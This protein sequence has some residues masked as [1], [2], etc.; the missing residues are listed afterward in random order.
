VQKVLISVLTASCSPIFLQVKDHPVR[1][2]C[3]AGWATGWSLCRREN[4]LASVGN[5]VTIPRSCTPWSSR[6]T[7]WATLAPVSYLKYSYLIF[8]LLHRRLNWEY[9]GWSGTMKASYTVLVWKP[10]RKRPEI[11]RWSWAYNQLYLQAKGCDSV[12][13]VNLSSDRVKGWYVNTI[14]QSVPQEA[15]ISR[16]ADDD[17]RWRGANDNGDD[18]YVLD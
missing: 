7:D 9:D 18:H 2:E 1:I 6:C 11:W 5:R 8:F 4:S 14:S 3:E 13:W 12:D 16:P 15:G 10:E 17:D